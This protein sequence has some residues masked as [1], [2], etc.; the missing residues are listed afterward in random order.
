MCL[1]KYYTLIKQVNK[2]ELSV[3]F[4]DRL[5]C[6]C[7]SVVVE[8]ENMEGARSWVRGIRELKEINSCVSKIVV[9][10]KRLKNKI[11]ITTN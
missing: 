9:L 10:L 4:L 7:L 2:S 11:Q 5:F 8:F 3:E 1:V 6:V